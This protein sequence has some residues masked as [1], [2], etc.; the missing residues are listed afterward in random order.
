MWS[1]CKTAFLGIAGSILVSFNVIAFDVQESV[2]TRSEWPEYENGPTLLSLP[3]LQDTLTRFQERPQQSITIRHPGGDAGRQ[4]G[5]TVH[6]W[7]VAFGVPLE[8]L[9]MEAGSGG[10]DQILIVFID[11]EKSE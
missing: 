6:Q 8:Y 10:A 1:L 3:A 5:Q 11:R 9:S 2:I 7:F 4:W